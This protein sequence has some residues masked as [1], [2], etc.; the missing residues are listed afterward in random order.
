MTK[1]YEGNNSGSGADNAI[2]RAKIKIN[3]KQEIGVQFN[4]A[5][6]SFSSSF[7]DSS[8]TNPAGTNGGN[9]SSGRAANGTSLSVELL[10][11]AVNK[12]VKGRDKQPAYMARKQNGKVGATSFFPETGGIL[13]SNVNTFYSMMQGKEGR[14]VEFMWGKMSF[15]GVL[16]SV[17]MDITLFDRQANPLRTSIRLQIRG[18]N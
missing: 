13:L 2:E 16:T 5:S 12:G 9:T 14:K 10:F 6:L 11:D 18:T 1:L 15:K 17:S 7:S 8:M 3:D 4:P